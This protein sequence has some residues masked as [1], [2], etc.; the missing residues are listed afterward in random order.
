MFQSGFL[1]TDA[2]FV[3]DLALT[4]EILFFLAICV[5]VVAQ[6]RGR[7]RLHDWIQTPV[8]TL[9]LFLIIFVMVASFMEQEVAS[10]LPQR[11][12][13]AYYLVVA[14]HAGLGLVAEGL[15][16]YALLA[17]HK[18]LPRKI[19]RLRHWMWATFVFWTAAV[20]AGVAT[21]YVWYVQPPGAVAQAPETVVNSEGVADTGDAPA[22]ARVS[23]Q[24]FAFAPADLTVVAGTEIVWV[25][26]DGAPHNVTLVDGPVASDNFF[27][28]ETFT[29][30][31]TEPG[32]YHIYCSLHGSSDG[33]GMAM[34]VTVLEENE[35]NAAVVAAAPTPPPPPT[36]TP[37]PTVPPPPVEPL[38]SDAPQQVVGLVSFFDTVAASD[39]VNVL[40]NGITPPQSGST[41]EAWLTDSKTDTVFSLGEVSPDEN[42]R[43]FFQFA[44]DGDQNLLGLYDGFLLTE[45]PQFDDDPSP[46]TVVY[47][48]QQAPEA[49]SH[50]RT[51][52]ADSSDAPAPYGLG[53]RRQAEEL[54]RHAEYIQ[55]AH[56][57]LSIADAQRHAEHVVNVLQGAEGEHFGDL[58]G[59]HGVQNPGDGFGV[60]PYVT[61]MQEA[62]VAAANA[63]DATNA[64]QVHSEHVVLATGN[65]LDWGAQIEEAA[66]EILAADS[67]GDIG[68]SVETIMH[69]S[70][71]LLNGADDNGDGQIA[72]TEG[73]IFT[74]YQHAQYMAAVPVSGTTQ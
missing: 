72:P 8:V 35:E 27:Q 56:D 28:D 58:D 24:N 39:S 62:A 45:E 51:I 70:N 33:S 50:I 36:P 19:G 54:L 63:P 16:I 10:T 64:I 22:P 49:L 5:G 74:A 13:D 44:G 26:Q 11:P 30:T 1:G 53:A 12:G 73:G 23:L 43:V 71:L 2:G 67:V 15:A 41:L 68:P 38:Q 55:T 4:A 17:G 61:R 40:L 57:L 21:Y 66:L 14:V 34:T 60:L 20:I 9:N 3:S 29:T 7:Y 52:A 48:G 18:I 69:F 42:G 6:R 46:G 32:T 47:R 37:A 25:N 31:F 59:A 65:A